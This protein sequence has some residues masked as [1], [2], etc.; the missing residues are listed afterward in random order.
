MSRAVPYADGLLNM[1]DRRKER[2]GKPR[3][4]LAC[5][6]DCS[7]VQGEAEADSPSHKSLPEGLSSP[8]YPDSRLWPLTTLLNSMDSGPFGWA[9]GS[10]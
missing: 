8:V 7:H 6:V 9:T 1:Q 10:L 2:E 5:P 3:Y 4:A